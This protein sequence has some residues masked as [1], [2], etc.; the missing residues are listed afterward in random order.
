MN[1]IIFIV[2]IMILAILFTHSKFYAQNIKADNNPFGVLAFLH[3]NHDWNS[4]KYPNEKSLNKAAAL[5]KESGAGWVRLDFI[6]QDIEPV[7][8][9]FDFNK[10]DLIV[11]VLSQR[12]IKILGILDYSADWASSC[13]QW[14]CKPVNNK[15]FVDY[16]VKVIS[17]YKGIVKH[18]EIWNEPDSSTYWQQQDGL[19]S[20]CG[21]LKDV[22]TAAKKTDPEC[23]I[24]NGGFAKGLISVN[25]L[26]DNGAKDY[27]DILNIHIFE[28]PFHRGAIKRVLSYPKQ[29]YK[30]M[31]R[32]GDGLKKIWITEIGCPG[33]RTGIKT[34]NSWMGKSPDEKKQAEWVNEVFSNLIYSEG[35]ERVFWAFFRDCRQ[36]WNNAIDYFGL[37]RWNFS[38]KPSF[39][40][41]RDCFTT[42]EKEK[43]KGGVEDVRFF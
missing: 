30:I 22:Y 6:W 11:K 7:R 3:W 28:S 13:G 25:R 40:A 1:K 34:A 2:F 32:N 43:R 35:V 9:K 20:Y 24:L 18:W 39:R 36:H 27:F 19:K 21:L 41:Y 5:I 16:A 8:G 42:W 26:Y 31:K 4:Y 10:Y 12:G 38:K 23:K 33:V 17:R 15:L 29:A 14:N 37:V